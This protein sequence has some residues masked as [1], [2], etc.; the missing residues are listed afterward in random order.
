MLTNSAIPLTILVVKGYKFTI[1]ALQ[2]IYSV[3]FKVFLIVGI[4]FAFN[5]H[6]LKSSRFVN[7]LNYRISYELTVR[8]K[9]GVRVATSF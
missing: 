7:F 3:V 8:L 5:R 4:T 9:F 1:I 6:H 2:L